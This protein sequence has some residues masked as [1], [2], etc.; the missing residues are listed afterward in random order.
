MQAMANTPVRSYPLR[1]FNEPSIFV[2]GPRAGQK[3]IPQSMQAH[4]GDRGGSIPPNVMGMNFGNQQALLAQQN[5]NM[6]ALERR[7]QRERDRSGSLSGVS[8]DADRA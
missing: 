2:L 6:E 5:S 7:A 4:V 8:R 1:N 3:V